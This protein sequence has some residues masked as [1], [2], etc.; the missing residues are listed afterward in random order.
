MVHG[1][2]AI[3]DDNHSIA[4]FGD[5]IGSTTIIY[6]VKYG[7]AAVY[8][9]Q[10]PNNPYTLNSL[11]GEA[12]TRHAIKGTH[13][14]KMVFFDEDGDQVPLAN[15][16]DLFHVTRM[17]QS[18]GRMRVNLGLFEESSAPVKD[19]SIMVIA[20]AA[21][22]VAIIVGWLCWRKNHSD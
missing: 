3:F 11:V 1:A 5:T 7:N 20:A 6:K 10:P 14:M 16:E 18:M 9:D 15:D 17:V 21:A 12:A 2:K 19:K 22:G 8:I 13:S 4:S